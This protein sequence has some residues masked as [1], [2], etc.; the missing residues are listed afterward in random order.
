[1]KIFGGDENKVPLKE[2]VMLKCQCGSCPVQAESVCSRPKLEKMMQMR[3]SMRNPSSESAPNIG[4]SLAPEP[5]EKMEMIPEEM[6]GVYCSI[7]KTACNDL[8]TKN[9]AYAISAKFT[10]TIHL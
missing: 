1:L 10:K 5:I 9:V 7:G 6:P 3:A 8:N 2:E 4:M